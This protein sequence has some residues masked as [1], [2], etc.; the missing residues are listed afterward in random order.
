M[1]LAALAKAVDG[2][3]SL[4][5]RLN[6]VALAFVGS[7]ILSLIAVWGVVTVGRDGAFYLHIAQQAS[8][9]GAAVAW[10]LFD[11]PWLSL[12]LAATHDLLHLPF[13]ASAYLWSVLFIAGTCALMVD[14]VRRRAPHAAWWACAAVLS[15]PAMNQFRGDIIRESGFWFF[16]TL[17][18][19]LAM[20]WRRQ[21]GWLLA[22]AVYV[23]VGLGSLFRLEAIVLGVAVVLA[24]LPDLLQPGR[25]RFFA[26]IA[27]WPVLGAIVAALA[28]L[29]VGDLQVRRWDFYMELVRPSALFAAFEQL[30][31]QFADSLVNP[32]SANEAGRIIFIG[33]FASLLIKCVS[34]MGPTA[35]SLLWPRCWRALAAY[36]REFR[37][38]AVIAAL[39]LAVLMLFFIRMQFIN[40]R[41]ISLLVL[42][43]VPLL[44]LAM[45]LFSGR[46]PRLA[47]GVAALALLM[48]LANVISTG[49]P[50]TQY[51]EAGH[52]IAAHTPPDAAIYYEDGRIAYYAGRGYTL[53]DLTREAVMDTALARSYRYFV[54]EAKPDEAW[55]QTWLQTHQA[56]VLAQFA[57]RKGNTMLVIGR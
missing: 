47:K 44:A 11:W 13:E 57:N 45:S 21:G 24:C 7:L 55:L 2:L 52:W 4:N 31:R 42:M 37:V 9:H 43:L 46:F 56:K 28:L 33:L 5:N 12:L 40:G 30:S 10:E 49:A 8:V 14:V 6:P 32:Y 51:I 36:W 39:Y 38:A 27:V 18:L 20:R 23:A 41:Y 17:T 16:C 22:A 48:M 53:S 15:M 35:L 29:S 1:R 3:S 34:L 26:Q 19:W 50:K 54:V 25:R